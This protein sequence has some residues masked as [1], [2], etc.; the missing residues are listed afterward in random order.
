VIEYRSE[1]RDSE[2]QAQEEKVARGN[3]PKYLRRLI[4]KRVR[5]FSEREVTFDFP[6]TALV[7]PN[8]GG[9]TTILGAAALAYKDV[10]PRRFFAKSGKYD[11]SMKDWVIEG[12]RDAW[13]A[14]SIT[15][16]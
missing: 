15:A 5:G 8:G 3:Y 11:A 14:P 16:G 7:G 13:C 1:I 6:V 2:I 4:L 9:K 12:V 10:P